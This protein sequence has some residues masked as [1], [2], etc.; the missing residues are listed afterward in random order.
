MDIRL[1]KNNDTYIQQA[2]N[3]DEWNDVFGDD[4]D[5]VFKMYNGQV[6]GGKGNDRIE[7]AAD[8]EPWRGLTAAYWD[9]PGAITVDLEAGF[10]DDGWGTRDTLIGVTSVSTGWSDTDL[11]G[12]AGDNEFY[13]GGNRN[14]VDGRGGYDTAWLP[15][16][17]QA[18]WSDFTIK[19]SIDGL[20]AVITSSMR[21]E[22]SLTI[23]NVEALGVAGH[24]DEK[25]SLFSFIKPEDVAVQGLVAGGDARWNAG[26]AMGT[27]AQVS[28]SFVTQAPASGAG[29]TGF[30]AFTAAEQATVRAIFDELSKLTGLSFKEVTEAG[31]AVGDVRFGASEQTT[32]KGVTSLPGSG[33]GGDVWMDLDSML[34]LTP[35]AEGYAALLHEIGHALGLRHPTNVDPGDH[36]AAQFHANFDMTGLTV[37]SGNASPDGLFPATWGALDVTALRA[38][39]G[40][41]AVNA[42]D[43][44]YQLSG[45]Q[46][47]AETSI[48]DD[49]GIDTI[50]ASLAVTGASINLTPG[51]VSSVGV[52]AGGASAINNL[53]LG[54]GT[55]IE[56]AIGSAFDD[57]LLGNDANNALKGG[58]G[59]DWID[60]GKGT[61]T[62]VFDGVRSDYL[63][64]SGYGKIF[65]TA[66]DGSSGF[67]TLLNT[68]VLQFADGSITL[69]KSA[70]G[71]DLAFAVD[72][73]AQAAGVLPDPSDE[74]RALVN[75]KIDAKPLHGTLT[76]NTDGSYVYV[77]N[78]S[79]SGNDSFSYILSDQAGGSNVYHTFI[80]VL[81][82]GGVPPVLGTEG[83]DL[84]N[85]SV[86][87]D[88]VDG[89]AGLDTFVVAGKR[90]DFTVVKTAKGYT[91][92]DNTG[93]QGMDSLVNVE[94]IK[95]NDA[96]IGLD[97]E[98][99]GGMAYRIYQ[100]AFGRSPDAAGL[101]YWLTQMDQGLT[102]RQVAQ[103]FVDSAEFKDLY[104]SNPTNAQVVEKFYQNVLHRAGEPAGVAYWN[105]IL[106]Q[107]Q[108]TVSGLL[109][110]FS[111]GFENHDALATVIGNGFTYIPYG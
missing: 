21:A 38:M 34:Q 97:A 82:T 91:L 23:T 81:P 52:T 46:F 51:Q 28:Y 10:A 70:F 68:E 43:T 72:Q 92:T 104:G 17:D 65:V 6:I 31:G 99:V 71:A 87:D 29:A 3:K 1:T 56:R 33:A 93:V 86:M 36:Y 39:Y 83:R 2:Q 66:R 88:Q 9:S 79:Y 8:A 84:L 89:G 111:E 24:W 58:L 26:A 63:L 75:Y 101:G 67:D 109:M 59:N 35:G 42:G 14:V 106:D 20:S 19:V 64:S 22:F 47:S 49:G 110:N 61:D 85:G 7:K 78:R 102:L 98:G 15:E 108:D 18:T 55:L 41:T 60:G 95:F 57:V 30:R 4:G 107:K 105:G 69:G 16:M 25:I 80:S 94:R 40:Q 77:P 5:D 32:T 62:A 27:A 73:S 103:S 44:V 53:S 74:A 13:V 45:L 96:S 50:D 12:S 54:T 90:A 76:L 11:K 100:A 37:M 48:T